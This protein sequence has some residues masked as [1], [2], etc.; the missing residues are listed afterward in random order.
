[1]Y[2]PGEGEKLTLRR[3]S[4]IRWIQWNVYQHVIIFIY[5]SS[6]SQ[7]YLLASDRKDISGQFGV[8]CWMLQQ[9]G[10]LKKALKNAYKLCCGEEAARR[11][12]IYIKCLWVSFCCFLRRE[13]KIRTHRLAGRCDSEE[14]E[15]FKESTPKIVD[16][17]RDVDVMIHYIYKHR[18][19][20]SYG[21]VKQTSIHLTTLQINW[22]SLFF[23]LVRAL[24][25]GWLR[26]KSI[27]GIPQI[28]SYSLMS[29]NW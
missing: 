4:L 5:M 21:Q 29:F 15:E 16:V 12:S 24:H 14:Y 11:F 9:K 6:L 7:W 22:F 26:L 17:G 23:L 8:L 18:L 13:K 27:D 19:I 25:R 20:Q 2:Q 3:V 28:T 1:M 10:K